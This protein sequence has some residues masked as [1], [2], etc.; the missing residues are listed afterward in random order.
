[1]RKLGFII[2]LLL[3]TSP[4]IAQSVIGATLI[5]G[6]DLNCTSG[7]EIDIDGDGNNEALIT[8]NTGLVVGINDTGAGV[9]LAGRPTTDPCTA[10]TAGMIFWN[11]T[12]SELCVCKGSAGD[13]VRVKDN[14]TSCF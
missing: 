13:G 11:S 10:K 14:A 3:L 12:N 8:S 1:M 2:S 9:V 6:V 4:A 5:G 7:C